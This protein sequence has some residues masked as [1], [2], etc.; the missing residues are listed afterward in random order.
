MKRIL[1][2]YVFLHL[3]TV[4]IYGQ[5]SFAEGGSWVFPSNTVCLTD[6]KREEIASMLAKNISGLVSSGQLNENFERSIVSFRFPMEWNV[7]F[8][9]Y[10]F[11]AISNFVDH[12]ENYPGLLRDY[13]CG[14]RTYDTQNGY[15]HS[16]TDYFLWPFDWNLVEEDAVQ[17]VAAAQGMI[18]GKDDGNDHHSCSFSSE[19]WNAVYL[20]H[21]DGS[22]T[23]YGHM[24]MNSLTTKPIGETVEEGEYLGIVGSSGNSTGPHLHFEVYDVS[25]LLIDPYAGECNDQNAESWWQDQRPYID[26]AINKIQTHDAPPQFHPCPQPADQNE[27]DV[28]APGEQVYFVT[29]FKDQRNTD[30]C[31]FTI[32]EPDGSVF[33][34][35][36]FQSPE[37]HYSASYWYWTNFIPVNAEEGE[38]TF[39][40]EFNEET[41][42]HHFIVSSDVTAL[43]EPDIVEKWD[44]VLRDGNLF[45]DIVCR[46][47]IDG[48]IVISDATGIRLFQKNL[49]V[50]PGFN[51]ITIAGQEFTTGIYFISLF[52]EGRV[53]GSGKAV[54]VSE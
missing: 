48:N 15:N 51:S 10:G 40:C 11:H 14:G 18:I 29:Y 42:V 25:G 49:D 26:P 24:K 50:S 1:S 35:W 9:D 27:R 21:A 20:L 19:N 53:I 28:F 46:S 6:E 43:E 41:Y 22:V 7:G 30:L 3:C 37:P 2:F 44:L 32:L 36:T 23:W 33:D 45:L 39:Q 12:D 13:N 38:W 16:G 8:N 47:A 17:V 4:C 52:D 5:R 54:I 31:I 34:T